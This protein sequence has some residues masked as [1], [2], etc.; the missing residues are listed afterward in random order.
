M[1]TGV[2]KGFSIVIG[3]GWWLALF[4]PPLEDLVGFLL[5]LYLDEGDGVASREKQSKDRVGGIY[6]GQWFLNRNA[7]AKPRVDQVS[8]SDM[9]GAVMKLHSRVK[10]PA[11]QA[12]EVD[13]LSDGLNGLALNQQSLDGL[14]DD[15]HT[16]GQQIELLYQLVPGL[17][18]H[19]L[20]R[21]LADIFY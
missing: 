17:L 8:I 18:S 20:R 2:T 4:A 7:G 16:H 3:W 9:L 12:A 21:T 11:I 6:K 14:G 13:A 10:G 1:I 19:R 5:A 15:F